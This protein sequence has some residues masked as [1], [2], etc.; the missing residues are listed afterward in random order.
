VLIGGEE[1]GGISFKGHIPE[2]DGP[3]MGL[4]LVEM[5]A[6]R[7][8][9]WRMVDELLADVGPAFYERV[10]LRLSRPVAKAEMTEFL[11]KKLPLRSA[12]QK[13]RRSVNATA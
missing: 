9:A 11:T 4:L 6:H 5:L 13:S 8:N 3:I 7:K 12:A 1:S 2:G 10:D